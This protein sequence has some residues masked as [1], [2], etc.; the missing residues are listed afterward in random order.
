MKTNIEKLISMFRRAA[1]ISVMLASPASAATPDIAHLSPV[2]LSIVAREIAKLR[3]P[4]ERALASKW[5]DAKKAA[6]FICR[7]LATKALKRRFKQADR[8]FLGTDD[9]NTLHLISSSRLEGSGQVRT[10]NG[11]QTF[12]FTCGLSPRT[13]KAVTFE[14]IP[15]HWLGYHRQPQ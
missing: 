14:T 2:Q 5:T 6:E 8:I 11:W 3:Y 10:I 1:L 9:P 4:A 15:S 12:T 13:G 7:P